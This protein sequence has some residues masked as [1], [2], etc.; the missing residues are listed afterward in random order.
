M[1]KGLR[2]QLIDKGVYDA[3]I[4]LGGGITQKARLSRSSKLRVEK[5]VEL[6]K[7][8]KAYKIIMSGAWSFLLKKNPLITEAKAMKQYA[9]RLGIHKKDV[10][11]EDYSEDTIGNAF[12]TKIRFLEP[13]N[14]NN[15]IVVT[16]KFHANRA[17]YVFKKVLGS[18]FNVRIVKAKDIMSNKQLS[19]KIKREKRISQLTNKWLQ[20]L[21]DGDDN[22]L[23]EFLFKKHP[24][25]S[26]KNLITR[27]KKSLITKL[28]K[29]EIMFRIL[30]NI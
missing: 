21:R 20:D 27:I 30:K 16:S 22:A 23:R 1:G 7:K 26:K 9:I 29:S 25:Y 28:I 12:F 2:K 14:W 5:A 17:L 13:N 8:K 3:I 19:K 15:V 24:G 11:V 10:L 4:V 18:G 6:F